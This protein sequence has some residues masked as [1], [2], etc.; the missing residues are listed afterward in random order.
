MGGWASFAAK[1]SPAKARPANTHAKIPTHNP[2]AFGIQAR[3]M[4]RNPLLFFSSHEGPSREKEPGPP[5]DSLLS[6]ENPGP[7][8]PGQKCP[9]PENLD[10]PRAHDHAADSSIGFHDLPAWRPPACN[11]HRQVMGLGGAESQMMPAALDG[12][13]R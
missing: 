9:G 11:R 4:Y 1:G 8:H 10:E 2:L 5:S 13:F 7:E 3:L 6:P 12:M